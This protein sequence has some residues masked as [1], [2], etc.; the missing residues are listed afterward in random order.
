MADVLTPHERAAIDAFPRQRVRRI[1]V[2]VSGIPD[3]QLRLGVH[4]KARKEIA[5]KRHFRAQRIAA[6]KIR[7]KGERQ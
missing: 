3:E 1:P 4:W 2:G 7:E 6:L 5:R